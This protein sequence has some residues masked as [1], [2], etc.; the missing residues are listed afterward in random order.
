LANAKC[1]SCETELIPVD[2]SE[3]T[4]YHYNNALWIGFHGAYSMFVDDIDSETQELQGAAHEAVICH[5]CAHALCEN[6]PWIN[7][8]LKPL[9]SH[10]HTSDYWKNNP[11]HSGW[12]KPGTKIEDWLQEYA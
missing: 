6:I 1:L 10:A 2:G 7:K 12:D 8:L 9:L 5:D 11:N 3:G 4:T